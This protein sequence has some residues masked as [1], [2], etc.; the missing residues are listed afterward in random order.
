MRC[1]TACGVLSAGRPSGR[2]ALRHRLARVFPGASHENRVRM[3]GPA[4]RRN[5]TD[6]L[7]FYKLEGS[8]PANYTLVWYVT[9]DGLGMHAICMPPGQGCGLSRE[10]REAIHEE[11]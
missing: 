7:H 11:L 8:R 1:S 4:R 6:S 9:V 5:L 10:R 3:P 2:L